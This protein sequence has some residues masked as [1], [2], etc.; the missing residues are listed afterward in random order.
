MYSQ[1]YRSLEVCSQIPSWSLVLLG[2]GLEK[3][4][5]KTCTEKPK[6]KWDRTAASMILQLVTESCHP[7]FRAFSVFERGELDIREYGKKSTRLSDNDRNVELLLRTI[8]SV[9]QLGI[10]GFVAHWSSYLDEDSSEAPSFDD[11]DSSGTLN[12]IQILETRRWQ[13]EECFTRISATARQAY[14]RN[15]AALYTHPP[16]L[17]KTAKSESTIWRTWR[18]WLCCWSEARMEVAWRAAGRLAA[19]FVFVVFIMARFHLAKLEFLLVAFFKTWHEEQWVGFFFFLKKSVGACGF[20][21]L[22]RG[23]NKSTGSVHRI[24]THSTPKLWECRKPAPEHSHST[25][26]AGCAV[27]FN[28]DTFHSDITVESIYFHDNWNG[29]HQAVREGPS[30]WVLHAVISRASFWRVRRNGK[31]FFYHDVALR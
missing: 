5:Y 28:K 18:I 22:E 30:G 6:S 4:W 31:S 24:H 7:L 3:K 19:Y 25:H 21:L 10:Y 8:K 11:S 13:K 12:A 2:P 1:L 27:L 17:T 23:A 9:N 26:Y 20:G 29:Q 14:G 15:E 16:K